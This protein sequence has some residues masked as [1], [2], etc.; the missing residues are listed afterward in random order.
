METLPV[1]HAA[2]IKNDWLDVARGKPANLLASIVYPRD[3]ADSK[4]RSSIVA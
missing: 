3:V 1:Q 2:V 4:W